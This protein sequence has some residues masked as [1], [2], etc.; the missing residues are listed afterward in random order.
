MFAKCGERFP[1]LYVLPLRA[2][3]VI[4]LFA[5]IIDEICV[6][7]HLRLEKGWRFLDIGAHVG[8][9]SV[10]GCRLVGRSGIVIAVE[11]DPQNFRALLSNTRLVA[12]NV[13]AVRAA[14]WNR[15]ESRT[16]FC[17]HAGALS[18]LMLLRKPMNAVTV[19]C[20]TMDSLFDMLARQSAIDRIDAVKVDV[21]G[22]EQEVLQGGRHVLDKVKLILV[23]V[24]DWARVGQLVAILDRFGFRV[25]ATKHHLIGTR[26]TIG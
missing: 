10:I 11:P 15:N 19:P 9:Y 20:L 23:E 24:H 21:E 7:T 8:A 25:E 2:R 13:I 4:S 16:F 17:S 12:R 3:A 18:S 26:E 1:I 5:N 22:A 14:M 6:I